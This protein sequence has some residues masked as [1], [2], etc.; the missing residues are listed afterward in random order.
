MLTSPFVLLPFIFP[1]LQ[2]VSPVQIFAQT[3]ELKMKWVSL[4]IN[5]PIVFNSEKTHQMKHTDSLSHW[6]EQFSHTVEQME[7][8]LHQHSLMSRGSTSLWLT[9]QLV[10]ESLWSSFAS[11]QS[12]W[13]TSVSS[14]AE[15]VWTMTWFFW[16]FSWFAM[17][18]TLLSIQVTVSS[19]KFDTTEKHSD[20]LESVEM[21]K[22]I[23]S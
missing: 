10:S 5:F 9:P 23:Q 7:Q 8:T 11:S 1:V 2:S 15:L 16:P 18:T 22:E 4:F 17:F 12:W 13:W 6:L 19:V 14:L 3:E 20:D 21:S